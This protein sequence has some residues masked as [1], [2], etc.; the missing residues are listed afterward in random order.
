MAIRVES[1]GIEVDGSRTSGTG[2]GGVG[3]VAPSA[4]KEDTLPANVEY[5]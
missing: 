1:S 4:Y 2:S 5:A 3:A